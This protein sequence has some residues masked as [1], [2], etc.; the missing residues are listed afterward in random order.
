MIQTIINAHVRLQALEYIL[1]EP[2]SIRKISN[3]GHQSRNP[4]C[5]RHR[6][7][8]KSKI[9][10][11]NQSVVSD[12]SHKFSPSIPNQ[13]IISKIFKD[14]ALHALLS[15]A[16]ACMAVRYSKGRLFQEM[17][18]AKHTCVGKK[19]NAGCK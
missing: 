9:P 7:T 17:P 4:K 11:I 2:Y 10:R 6:S 15:V 19:M 3:A 8:M 1:S 18:L 5:S 16:S 14:S 13:K 12:F